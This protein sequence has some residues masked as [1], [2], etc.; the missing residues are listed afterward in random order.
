MTQKNGSI[1]PLGYL[2]ILV[3]IFSQNIAGS[4]FLFHTKVRQQIKGGGGGD[5]NYVNQSDI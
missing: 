5:G 1:E 3:T 4:D 2:I